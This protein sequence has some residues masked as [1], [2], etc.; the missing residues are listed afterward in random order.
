MPVN[1]LGFVDDVCVRD[2]QSGVVTKAIESKTIW[3]HPAAWS[4]D[5][6]YMLVKYDE[7]RESSADEL[8]IWSATTDT[9][10]PFVKFEQLRSLLSGYAIGRLHVAGERTRRSVRHDLSRTAAN[11]AAHHGR[12]ECPQLE[13]GRA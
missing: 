3:E 9:L 6:R 1:L 2:M 5:G 11:L 8:R 13:R 12:R 10:S 4:A 7:Y